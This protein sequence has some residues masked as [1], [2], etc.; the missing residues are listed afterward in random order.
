[1]GIGNWSDP[2]TLKSDQFSIPN[3]HPTGTGRDQ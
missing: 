3:S 1:L 2:E